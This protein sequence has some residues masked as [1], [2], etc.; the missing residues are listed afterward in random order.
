MRK[1][2]RWTIRIVALTSPS[3]RSILGDSTTTWRSYNRLGIVI[4]HIARYCFLNGTPTTLWIAEV[5][6]RQTRHTTPWTIIMPVSPAIWSSVSRAII[7]IIT[8]VTIVTIVTRTWISLE[9]QQRVQENV[10]AKVNVKKKRN[11]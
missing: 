1:S 8:P 10:V 7:A 5:P 11:E 3:D 4:D 6:A 2:S 9:I